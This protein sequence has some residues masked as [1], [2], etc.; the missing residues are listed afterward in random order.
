MKNNYATAS[1]NGT[2][3]K[4]SYCP[5]DDAIA[6]LDDQYAIGTIEVRIITLKPQI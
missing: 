2:T 6:L 1:I 4:I 3:L 5:L